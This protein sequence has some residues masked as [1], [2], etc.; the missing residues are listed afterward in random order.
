M[1]APQVMP[2]TQP[3][4]LRPTPL[5]VMTPATAAISITCVIIPVIGPAGTVRILL[6]RTGTYAGFYVY[7]K[8]TY[9]TAPASNSARAGHRRPVRE[10]P[11]VAT[12]SLRTD[13]GRKPLRIR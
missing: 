7:R 4:A 5:R 3:A 11:Y 10:D 2:T 9:W 13:E 6:A 12:G 8:R 1:T